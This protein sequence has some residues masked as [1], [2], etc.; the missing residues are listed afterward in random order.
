MCL[1]SNYCTGIYDDFLNHPIRKFLDE[2]VEVTIG[3]DDPIQF[4]TDL[5]KEYRIATKIDVNVETLVQNARRLL[6][7]RAG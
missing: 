6:P 3:T 4:S 5:Q 2:G 1:S 7:N